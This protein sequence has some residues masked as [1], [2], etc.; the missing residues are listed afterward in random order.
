MSVFLSLFQKVVYFQSNYDGKQPHN[1]FELTTY[2]IKYMH[3]QH[4][5]I[6]VYSKEFISEIKFLVQNLP[7]T[8]QSVGNPGGC[9]N[10]P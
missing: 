9:V 6:M 7:N 4:D 5:G 10:L 2:C 8:W 3:E 1:F